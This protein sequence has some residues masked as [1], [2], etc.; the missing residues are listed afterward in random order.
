MRMMMRHESSGLENCMTQLK[1]EAGTNCLA[2]AIAN[3]A[4]RSTGSKKVEYT[5]LIA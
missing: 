1:A 4:D 5:D 2:E 3:A